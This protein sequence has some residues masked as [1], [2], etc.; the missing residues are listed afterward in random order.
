[1]D[2]NKSENNN[3]SQKVCSKSDGLENESQKI[4]N[5]LGD[6]LWESH[7]K[8]DLYRQRLFKRAL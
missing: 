6:F 4:S 3:N 5:F 1:M 8:R 2:F 7:I